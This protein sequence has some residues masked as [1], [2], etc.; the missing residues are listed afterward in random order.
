MGKQTAYYAQLQSPPAKI[1]GKKIMQDQNTDTLVKSNNHKLPDWC[2]IV[3]ILKGTN[4]K[5]WERD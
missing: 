3:A 5:D 2:L 1:T 4:S